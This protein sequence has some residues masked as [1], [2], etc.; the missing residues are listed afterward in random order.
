MSDGLYLTA[1]EAAA[2]LGVSV[3]TLYAYVSR[4][5]IRSQKAPGSRS[6]RY[7]RADVLRFKS[8]LPTFVPRP[9]ES[10]L[11]RESQIT[12]ITEAG[13]FYRGQSAVA[14]AE[15]ESLE[16]VAAA[17][18][19][20][21]E[22][23]VFTDAAPPVPDWVKD[24]APRL[25]GLPAVDRAMALFPMIERHSV[26]AYDLSPAGFT[27][28]AADAMR[29]F[30]AI[31][32][33]SCEPSAAPLHKVIAGASRD[34]SALE[35]VVRRLLVLAA[36]HELDPTT[37]AVRA[38]ANTGVTPYRVILAGFLASAGR[39]LAYGR[40]EALLRLID[41]V[42]AAK[43]PRDVVIRRIRDGEEIP[44]FGSPFYPHG[45]PRAHALLVAMNR[46]LAGD[47]QLAR[48]NA[49]FEVVFEVTGQRPSFA[50]MNLFLSRKLGIPGQDGITLRLG[51][52]AGWI[53]HA[54]EQF[55]GRDLVRPRTLYTGLLPDDDDAVACG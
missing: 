39:R 41:E 7:W 34:G 13:P 27:R 38:V 53:A 17:L 43:D 19:Q 15:T 51:R 26:R 33:G 47:P 1:E 18:W 45:D 24:M 50:M 35:E 14:L 37:Y 2:E 10:D 16:A 29:W 9:G 55:Q 32:V 30:G 3:T 44:G 5:I 8:G 42:I 28:T 21:D 49:A 48:L 25:Q 31:I 40:V 23:A 36:D 20:V 11:V 6:A 12:L 22:S 4:K 54:V 46:D 52:I